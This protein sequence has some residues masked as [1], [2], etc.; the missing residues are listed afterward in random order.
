MRVFN[1]LMC[2]RSDS[3]IA[4]GAPCS[5]NGNSRFITRYF[6]STPAKLWSGCPGAGKGLNSIVAAVW[7]N[8]FFNSGV[9][10]AGVIVGAVCELDVPL[11][12]KIIK[13]VGVNMYDES[14]DTVLASVCGLLAEL[15][16]SA[17]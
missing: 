6:P 8:A 3:T 2:P 17:A 15:D 10:A 14:S 16:S 12:V 5:K 4:G 7:K 11:P 1:A 13:R 9:T